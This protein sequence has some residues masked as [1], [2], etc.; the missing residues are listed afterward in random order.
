MPAISQTSRRARFALVAV[1][2]ATALSVAACGSSNTA[3]PQSAAPAPNGSG[4]PSTSA[5]P[6]ANG[7]ARVSGLIASVSGN[8][9]QVTRQKGNA[10]VDFTPSTKVTEVT[11]GSLTDVTTGSCVSV[12]PTHGEPQGAQPVTAAAVRV[13]QTADGK[14]PQG[15]APGTKHPGIQ[16]PVAAVS[17]NTINVSTPGAGGNNG[18][19][20]V[21]VN[22]QTRYSKQTPGSTQSIA[23]GQCLTAQGSLDTGGALQATTINLRPARNGNC[24]GEGGKPAHGHGG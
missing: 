4:A 12:R 16:G 9:A 10:T 7:H 20:A 19:T 1:S 5:S 23:Q 6:P 15:A 2:A 21:T 8:A 17:G 18:Q 13:T 14:C 24:P 3:S 11:A 22:D